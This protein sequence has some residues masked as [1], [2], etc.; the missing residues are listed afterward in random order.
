MSFSQLHQRS[1]RSRDCAVLL[2]VA[3]EVSIHHPE[4]VFQWRD[5][6]FIG[7]SEKVVLEHIPSSLASGQPL[8]IRGSAVPLLDSVFMGGYL[9]WGIS[10]FWRGSLGWKDQPFTLDFYWGKALHIQQ[11]Y[12]PSPSISSSWV[13]ATHLL[14][15]LCKMPFL[16]RFQ[17]ILLKDWC[18]MLSGV[19]NFIPHFIWA[20][21][22]YVFV[23]IYFM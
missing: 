13:A 21:H 9:L 22:C 18:I 17:P 2:G 1:F 14:W 6:L 11:L 12:Q 19:E 3:E 10:R 7:R 23:F 8:S 16:Y 15:H 4:L 20:H 5:F